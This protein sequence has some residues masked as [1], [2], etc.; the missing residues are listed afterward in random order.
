MTPGRR[1]RLA[2]MQ[3]SAHLASLPDELFEARLVSHTSDDGADRTEQRTER[4]DFGLRI[5]KHIFRSNIGER[6]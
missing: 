6:G 2:E 3:R 5:E 4:R 1:R